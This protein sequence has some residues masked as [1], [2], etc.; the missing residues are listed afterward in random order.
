MKKFFMLITLSMLIMSTVSGCRLF[1]GNRNGDC[2]ESCTSS[3]NSG[4]LQGIPAMQGL[5]SGPI[6]SNRLE[7]LPNP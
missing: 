7:V 4:I 3:C 2:C 1:G 6:N 5:P